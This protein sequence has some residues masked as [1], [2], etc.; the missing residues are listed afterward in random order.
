MKYQTRM[1]TELI[2]RMEKIQ[3]IINEIVTYAGKL[4]KASFLSKA[5]KIGL[6]DIIDMLGGASMFGEE[7][8]K[9]QEQREKAEN[10]EFDFDEEA[11]AKARDMFK[12]FNVEPPKEEQRKIRQV[13]ISLSSKFHPDKARNDKDRADFHILMQEINTAYQN[14]DIDK[15]LEIERLYVHSEAID[16]TGKAVTVDVLTEEIKRLQ[17][18]LEFLEGQVKRTSGEI[19]NF[20]KSDLGKAL[21]T[22]NKMEKEGEGLDAEV[23]Q[24]DETAKQMSVLHE[25][26]KDS[27]D[28]Q[29]MSPKFYE[30]LMSGQ[31]SPFEDF[32]DDD[33]D[34]DFGDI[35]GGDFDDD[36]H[37]MSVSDTL[38]KLFGFDNEEDDEELEPVKNPRFKDEETV[39]VMSNTRPDFHPET[40][41]KGLTGRLFESYMKDDEECYLV[42]FDHLSLEKLS[43]EYINEAAMVGLSFDEYTFGRNDLKKSKM[44]FD[45]NKTA[46]LRYKLE[47]ESKFSEEEPEIQKVITDAL[48]QDFEEDESENWFNYFENKLILP[49]DGKSRGLLQDMKKGTKVKIIQPVAAHPMMGIIVLCLVGKKQEEMPYPLMDL[50]VSK[51]ADK[52]LEVILDA[53]SIWARKQTPF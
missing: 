36:D 37:E 2:S 5:D 4:R 3:K 7:F 41:L 48:L 39:K 53:Y 14:H 1:Q 24:L 29:Q 33:S 18:E 8:D 35:F 32:E 9:Y 38:S 21:T 17:R 23:E 49:L 26:L 46:K 22:K 45:V 15:L 12:E 20:R 44:D 42:E 51:R 30:A 40:N 19:K 25:A 34:F 31:N 6:K 10:G 27:W 50:T 11:K 13:F 52:K 16:L 43:R 28:K 47:L